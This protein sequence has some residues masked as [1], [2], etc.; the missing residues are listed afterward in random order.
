MPQAAP[1]GG[2]RPA[3]LWPWAGI[4]RSR[5]NGSLLGGCGDL[6]QLAKGNKEIKEVDA[7]G[8]EWLF[9]KAA[10]GNKEIKKVDA[11]H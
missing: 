8:V 5:G 10:K 7:R 3:S 6:G 1:S 4:S 11:R 9:G 2:L